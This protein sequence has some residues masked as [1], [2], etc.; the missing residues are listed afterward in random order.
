MLPQHTLAPKLFNPSL[1]PFALMAAESATLRQFIY[2][3]NNK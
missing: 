2:I 1:V 3:E